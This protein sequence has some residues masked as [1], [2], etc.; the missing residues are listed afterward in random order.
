M[1]IRSRYLAGNVDT[2]DGKHHVCSFDEFSDY[3][4]FLIYTDNTHSE[5]VVPSHIP[6]EYD[7]LVYF[8][9]YTF[10][11]TFDRKTYLKFF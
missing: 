2:L 3:F 1:N 4:F 8:C 7:D 10:Y 5:N 6:N 11:C 9:V